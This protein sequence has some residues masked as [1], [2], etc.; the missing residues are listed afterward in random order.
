TAQQHDY[1]L[2]E[3]KSSGGLLGGSRTQR[4]EVS[5]TRAIGSEVSTGGDLLIASGQDQTYRAARLDSGGDIE[6]QSGGT[7]RFETA[8]DVHT[9]SHERSKSS[10]A[11]QSSS[12]EGFTRETLRQS[13]LVAQGE[14]II[15]AADGIQI[16]VEKIDRRSVTRTIDAMVAANP[17]LA[18]L[19]EMEQRGD[20]DWRRVKAFHDSWDYEQSGLGAGAA[21][22]VAIVAAAWAGPAASG[23]L[24]LAEAGVAASMV[25]AGAGSLAGTGAVSLVNNRGDLGTALGDTFSSDSLRGAATAALSAGM[26]SRVDNV[27]GGLT[28]TSTNT[29]SGLDLRSIGGIGRFAGHRV[30]HGI[31]N[32]GLQTAI[33]GGS[34]ERNLDAALQGA[35]HHVASGVLFNA[36]GDFSHNRFAN[37]SPEKIALHALAGGLTAEAM[38]GDFR[39]GA[40]AAGAN[41]ALVEYLDSQ[42]GSDP[43][44]RTHFLTTA[45]QLVGIVAAELVNGD[46]HQ[47]A[48]IAAQATRYNYLRHDQLAMARAELADCNGESHCMEEVVERYQDLSQEQHKAAVEACSTDLAAC[49]EH[50][51]AAANGEYA[52]YGDDSLWDLPTEALPYMQALFDENIGVQN[53]FGEATIARSLMEGAGLAPSV[54]AGLAAAP[55]AVNKKTSRTSF[56]SS[57]GAIVRP[58]NSSFY[59]NAYEIQLPGTAYPG[60]SR[61]RHNQ[62][63][64]QALH[65]AF[66]ADPG[67][68]SRMEGLYP[69]IV[70]GVSPGPR[71]AFSRSAPTPDVT[72]HHSDTPGQ[73]QLIPRDQHTA[74]GP[75]Q[76]TLHP[77]GSGG[78]FNWGVR[79]D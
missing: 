34:F 51:L 50:S 21:L 48:E 15:Q 63:S 45:S 8:S 75:V 60:V 17:D 74:P 39:T 24:G 5:K 35:V 69:G 36:V 22:V 55:W 28:N 76:E 32:A 42:L 41:E 19:Q 13:E 70:K 9:E 59:S 33:N 44:T 65:E 78:Y 16:D 11:W 43:Q 56:E 12:G 4:D 6:L 27:W 49:Q 30:T 23:L 62:L 14:L 79:H 31:A 71:G 40:M 72:W 38:G 77:S 10:F 73:M 29:T 3:K 46:V 25:S 57:N 1:S 61:Q 58:L 53:Q 54:A 47:G 52:R 66:Q 64:N 37:G 20:V 26:T 68:A 67:F 2:Y 7:I 18:W